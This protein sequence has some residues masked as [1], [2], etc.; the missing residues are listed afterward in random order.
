MVGQDYFFY[1]IR[2]VNLLADIDVLS[3]W[4]IV[5]GFTRPIQLHFGSDLDDSHIITV[6]VLQA[7]LRSHS[8]TT[9]KVRAAMIRPFITRD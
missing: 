7:F 8:L 6:F 4:P 9:E 5:L 2:G 3:C 1:L